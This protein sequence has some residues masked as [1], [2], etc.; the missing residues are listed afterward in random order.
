MPYNRFRPALKP[1]HWAALIGGAVAALS[2]PVLLDSVTPDMS[3]ATEEV[4]C[5]HSEHRIPS[6]TA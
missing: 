1:A 4:T 6:R 2:L 5:E 3:T